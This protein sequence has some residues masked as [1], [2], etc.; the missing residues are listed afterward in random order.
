MKINNIRAL[1]DE[2]Y[3]ILDG[4]CE[5]AVERALHVLSN[6]PE[7]PESYLLLSE[8]S[9][10]GERLDHAL[11]WINRGLV[12]NPTHEGLLFKKASILLDGFEDIDEAFAILAQLEMGFR[13]QS[14][15]TLKKALGAQLIL[16]VYLLLIDCFRLKSD[17]NEAYQHALI[18]ISIAPNDD[19]ALL[20]FATA[21]F[22]IGNYQ[23]ALEMIEP[24]TDKFEPSDFY[25][26]K[27]QIACAEG[28]FAEA[29]VTFKE[30]NRL[31]KTRYHRPIRL[32][33]RSFLH[34][35]DQALL[36]LPREIREFIHKTAVELHDVIPIDLILASKGKLSP[37]ACITIEKVMDS[38]KN[39]TQIISLFRKNIENLASRKQEIK[40]L[41]AS[42]L[43]HELGRLT[44]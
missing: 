5:I 1:A 6:A 16:D 22:E 2:A 17:F 20:A 39:E 38:T 15:A 7:D 23:K 34:A 31:D 11:T 37:T 28:Q 10:E 18:A 29:D 32:D 41:I 40:D 30:A 44:L 8:V 24:I 42:A 19:N 33:E 27:A 25:W 43:L 36:A 13:T 3:A 4:K 35:F 21:H 26:L 14:M 9:E 12:H